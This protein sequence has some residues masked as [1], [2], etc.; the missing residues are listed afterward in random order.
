MVEVRSEIWCT[1]DPKYYVPLKDNN[2]L[3]QFYNNE[4]T[5]VHGVTGQVLL[6][7][8][9]S[10]RHDNFTYDETIGQLGTM[11][12]YWDVKFLSNE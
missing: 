2:N 10:D 4:M 11:K 3:I 12:S 5:S 1:E 8:L 6:K 7:N 9:I